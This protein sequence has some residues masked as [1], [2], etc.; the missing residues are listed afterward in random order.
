MIHPNTGK[1]ADSA[2]DEEVINLNFRSLEGLAAYSIFFTV[3]N[4]SEYGVLAGGIST[5][6]PFWTTAAGG[7]LAL[8]QNLVTDVMG[9]LQAS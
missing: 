8:T 5:R 1:A 7:V 4:S 9:M 3:T 2:I 6:M